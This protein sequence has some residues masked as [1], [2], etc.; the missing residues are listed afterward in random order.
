MVN[1]ILFGPDTY[2]NTMT[3]CRNNN[4]CTGFFGDP[5]DT[6]G[7]YFAVRKTGS[8]ILSG[9]TES[10]RLVTLEA[11]CSGGKTEMGLTTE[12]TSGSPDDSVSQS[13]CEVY[14]GVNWGGGTGTGPEDA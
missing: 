5:P 9:R 8:S 12:E 4:N 3:Y 13:E 7:T 6:E 14:G 1:P 2:T 10:Y 11:S